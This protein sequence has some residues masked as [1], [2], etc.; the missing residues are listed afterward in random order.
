MYRQKG[1]W[2][3]KYQRSYLGKDAWLDTLPDSDRLSGG[4]NVVGSEAIFEYGL[5]KNVIL[6]FDY[7]QD[8]QITGAKNIQHL[9]QADMVVKF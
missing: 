3:A 9:I 2:Q 5:T 1:Q 4:T 6:G 8:K 7:Y